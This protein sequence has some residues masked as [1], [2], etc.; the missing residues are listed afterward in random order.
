M[1]TDILRQ[2]FLTFFQKKDH[3][4]LPSAPLVPEN[5]PTLLFTG[6]GMNPF[7]EYFV[8]I[9]APPSP[10]VTTCQKCLRTV[11]IEKVG[12][13]P[14]HHTFFEMMGNFSFGDYFKRDAIKWAW[15]FL[16][17]ELKIK[18]EKLSVSIYEDDEESYGIWTKEVGLSPDKIFKFTAKDNFWPA[19]APAEG[20]NGPCGPCSEIFYDLGTE[21]GCGLKECNVNCDCQ[22]YVEI[23]NLVFTQFDR[24][25]DGS[26]KP[27]PQK[28]IDTGLGLERL[29]AVMQD[30]LSN[31]DNDVF[32]SIIRE[33]SE[34]LKLTYTAS[35]EEGARIRRI[36]DHVRTLVF[37]SS[38]GVIPS[39]EGRGY[40]VRRILRVAARDGMTL[41]QKK[42]FLYKLVPFV[43]NIMKHAYPDLPD[44]EQHITRIVKSE[45]TKFLET[46]D[47]GMDLLDNNIKKL[48]KK[49]EKVFPGEEAFK[50]YDTYGFPIDLTKSILAEKGFQLDM[51]AY[52]ESM[53]AQ[54]E[55]ARA[56][57]KIAQQIFAQTPITQVKQILK[58]TKFT[59]YETLEEEVKI[60]AILADGKLV[61]E[62]AQNTEVSVITEKTPFYGESGGQAGDTGWIRK[63]GLEIVIHDTQRIE[64][65]IIHIGKVKKGIAK[66][67]EKATAIVDKERRNSIARNHTATHL[68]QN[69]L[70]KIIGEHVEQAGSLVEPNRL[71]FDFSHFS[72]ITKEELY[73]IEDTVNELIRGNHHVKTHNLSIS[74]AK[75]MGALAFFGE[76]YGENVRVI[77]VSGISRELCGG[78]H[79][80]STGEIG[81][82]K[83]TSE[84]SIASGTRR[85]EAMT[86]I[87]AF[88]SFRHQEETIGEI[89]ALVESTPHKAVDKTKAL[90]TELKGLRQQVA[91]YCRADNKDLSSTLL[92]KAKDIKGVKLIT[93]ILEGK[94]MDDMRSVGDYIKKNPDPIIALLG[95]IQNQKANL[96]LILSPQLTSKGLDAVALIKEISPIIGGSGGGRK[97]MAQA[98]GKETTKIKEAMEKFSQIISEKI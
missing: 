21:Y 12:R 32:L 35:T 83:I 78:T 52:Q 24:Q 49:G 87:S 19:N 14:S 38:E 44:K 43:I 97:D 7:K 86:G 42:P 66:T 1:K 59:G 72:S 84:T 45:E 5:D 61:P 46:V 18:P 50:L 33:T 94:T 53:K 9:A 39:N 67:G 55:Q 11:D 41:G 63:E 56:F 13:T 10:R 36:S 90:L 88:K 40:V 3:K 37:T 58:E 2:K 23:W 54:R 16:T 95:T 20:P 76:K 4:I 77:E 8:G 98:G 29:A 75:K 73:L 48:S 25:E 51:K 60:E 69:A 34:L 70:R 65:Y 28:N 85:I 26:L 62:A 30:V 27:L 31:F 64:N 15:E 80:A 82:F 57:S 96:V 89:S 6:A 92:S 74:E 22:R 71:R 47:A 68:L 81:L 93:E 17:E 91:Q 79:T